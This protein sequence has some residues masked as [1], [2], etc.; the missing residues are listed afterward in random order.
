MGDLDALPPSIA[1]HDHVGRSHGLFPLGS[2]MRRRLLSKRSRSLQGIY[3]DGFV[4]ALLFND[5]DRRCAEEEEQDVS[6]NRTLSVAHQAHGFQEKVRTSV[7]FEAGIFAL[8][9]DSDTGIGS[10][11]A[12]K[13]HPAAVPHSIQP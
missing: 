2:P 12:R 1:T 5:A 6:A 13:T 9:P 4:A 7:C 3:V 11:P 8:S 10:P